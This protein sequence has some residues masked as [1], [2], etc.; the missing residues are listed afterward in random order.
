MNDAI[1]QSARAGHPAPIR[2]GFTRGVAPSKWAERWRRAVPERPIELVPISRE[3]GRSTHPDARSCDMLIERAQPGARPV[4]H[5]ADGVRTH[6]AMFL[7]EEAVALVVPKDHELASETSVSADDLALVTLLDYPGHAPEWPRAQPWNDPEWMPQDLAAALA[8]VAT[9]L[10]V[11]LAPLPLAQHAANKSEH[12][13]VRV[14]QPL[15]GSTMWAT[16]PVSS[17]HDVGAEAPCT[18]HDEAR[19]VVHEPDV[20]QLA[21]IL[22]GRTA[23]SSR[24]SQEQSAARGADASQQR[25]KSQQARKVQ[26]SAAKKKSALKP[27]SRGAQLAAAR[28]K[29]AR[30]R[31]A[32]AA[33]KRKKR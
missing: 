11:I 8:L 9:G 31:A 29:A 5:T 25:Q 2:L 22:R 13:V 30:N 10:G 6:H 28:E 4:T 1:T 17:S 19:D 32:K 16:W 18:D 12:A 33:A 14:D 24:R 26:S 23:A 20:Q 27:N 21:G 15:P 3:F 7:Y